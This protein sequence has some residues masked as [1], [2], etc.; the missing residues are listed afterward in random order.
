MDSF[1]RTQAA[2]C[3]NA[4]PAP[5]PRG[6]GVRRT[7]TAGRIIAWM[8]LAALL[9]GCG[10]GGT[11]ANVARPPAP[12]AP[13]A[14]PP[15][16]VTTADDFRTA[17]F[18]RSWGLEAIG[19][20]EAYAEGFTGE[21]VIIGILDF[22]FVFESTESN[23][24]AASR[25]LDASFVSIYEAQIGEPIS[26]DEHGQAVAVVAA[27]IKND[28]DTHGVAFGATVL[29]VDFFSGVNETQ[30]V[31][32]GI[33][34]HVSNPWTFLTDNGARVVNKSLGFD[35]DDIIV[36]PPQ[37]SEVYTVDT[38]A[39]V[40]A[41]GAL[42]VTSAG[43][44][45]DADPQ[46][47]ALETIDILRDNN[48]L[49]NGPGAFIIVG[50]VDENLQMASFSDRAG[51]AK[52]FYLVAPGVDVV[53]PW[54]GVLSIGSGTSFSAPHVTGAAAILFQRWPL[55]TAREVADILFD[56]ATDLGA[57]GVDVI[58]GHGLLN[59]AAA[60]TPLGVSTL[61]VEGSSVAA[62]VTGAALVLG[63]AFGDAAAF[64]SALSAVLMLDGFARD[65]QIDLSGFV[66][67]R[68][69]RSFLDDIADQRRNWRSASLNLGGAGYLSVSVNED[70]RASA[71]LPLL[72]QAVA[73]FGI[74]RDLVLEFAG[75][76]M[77]QRFTAGTGRRL[78]D[79]LAVPGAA[80][81]GAELLSLT[82]A[83]APA[84]DTGAGNYAIAGT[85]LSPNI[86][87]RLGLSM[88][89]NRGLITHP[90]AGLR[91]REPVYAAALRLDRHGASSRLALEVGTL[92]EDAAIL[93]SRA[94]GGLG[95]TDHSRTVWTTLEAE[96][97]FGRRLVLE[98]SLTV[99]LTDPGHIGDSLLRSLGT[100]ASSGF[101][102][103]LS[104][105]DLLLWGDAVSITVHQPL[106]VER[107]P[108]TLVSGTGL[109]LDTGN[110]NFI[111]T[112][113]SLTPSGREIALEGAYRAYV[114]GW[115]AEA[116]VAYRFDA[117]HVAGRRD[118]ITMLWLSR[119]F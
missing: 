39:H 69:N 91:D 70:E 7:R 2:K 119:P 29:A 56:S 15:I 17:E 77:G 55:L 19:A 61:A 54:N 9:P 37:V 87:L 24:H 72:G 116:N 66:L 8:A 93:G 57:P 89:S 1:F 51:I 26:T 16:P 96:K 80:R 118:A 99:A 50:A 58:F 49:N 101:S 64:R 14:P 97:R 40:V 25:G 103:G 22:N 30:V 107:A 53:F 18:D 27:G 117:D 23:F 62:P 20:A 36:N 68:P 12:L 71:I 35:E 10:G 45:G 43:N 113:L 86:E 11:V 28:F 13:P 76:V 21:G 46:L 112:V 31:Q 108:L 48:L 81:L 109:D 5:L 44:N 6:R 42:L 82:R 41:E 85:S 104:G 100:I 114:G 90:V 60:M 83:F 78:T 75:T 3:D 115:R 95:I 98:A 74:R 94:A 33:L 106:H 38:D 34:F 67:S 32:D 52:D 102:V 4:G 65:F 88:A 47:S 63:S 59:L 110:V 73:D 111:E 79:A 84:I 92:A 105:R